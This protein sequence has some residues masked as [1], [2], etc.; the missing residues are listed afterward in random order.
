MFDIGKF[1]KSA[2]ELREERDNNMWKSAAEVK[3][4]ANDRYTVEDDE[5]EEYD[6]IGIDG[7]LAATEKL[8]AVNKGIAKEDIRDSLVNDRVYTVPKLMAERIKLDHGKV[9]RMSMR[10]FNKSR[11]LKGLQPDT[12]GKYTVGYLIS[13]PLAAPLEEINPLQLVEQQTRITK[14]GP[15][16]IGDPNAITAD[17][18]NVHASQFGFIDPIAGPESDRAGV[19]TRMANGTRIGS[20]GR[21]YQRMKNRRT[22]KVEWVSPSDLVGKVVKLPD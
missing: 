13:N 3:S 4:K 5:H 17:M 7:I 22:G 9:L 10:R 18:Q 12:F 2:R 20:D 19:D 21:I 16:G 8:L 14:M 1:I 15:G 11:S 6:R